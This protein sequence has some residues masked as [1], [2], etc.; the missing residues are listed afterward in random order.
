MAGE[1]QV[2]CFISAA[3][4]V[5]RIDNYD[6]NRSNYSRSVLQGT[7]KKGVMFYFAAPQDEGA[8]QCRLALRLRSRLEACF[9]AQLR[10]LRNRYQDQRKRRFLKNRS[11]VVGNALAKVEILFIEMRAF[12]VFSDDHLITQV[13]QFI[14]TVNDGKESIYRILGH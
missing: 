6:F 10:L 14:S 11:E 4:R 7:I 12:I 8:D 3:T 2:R 5:A 13:Q 1:N 9:D